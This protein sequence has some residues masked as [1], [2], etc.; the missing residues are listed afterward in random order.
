MSEIGNIQVKADS[1][2]SVPFKILSNDNHYFVGDMLKGI[3]VYEKKAVGVSYLCFIECK[4][5]K[6]FELADNRLFCNNMVD[7]VV[8][9]VRDPVEIN[10]LHRQKNHFNRFTNYKEYWNIPYVEGKGLIVG[11]EIHELT[12]MITEK[13]SE[14][15]FSNYDELYGNLTTKV[16]PDNWFSNHPEYDKPYIGMINLGTN[17]IYNYGSYNS[18]TIS[19]YRWGVFSVREEDL[20]TSPRGN[21]APPY[22]YS[23]AFPV[24]MFFEDNLIYILGTGYS[25]SGYCDCITYNE[26]Y[27]LTYHLYFPNFKP[28]DI[29]YLPTMQAFFVV[30]GQSVWGAFK[31][32]ETVYMERYVDYEIPTDATSIFI[33]GNNLITLGNQLSVYS[34]FENELKLV[35][36]YPDISGTCYLKKGDVLAV[37]N[38]QG[39]FFYDITDLKNIRLIP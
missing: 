3:H 30:S 6:D 38:T 27:P 7:M 28:V 32:S 34:P 4:N 2:F 22:Y 29:T 18:W 17:E 16:I 9:D 8:I 35:K 39:M 5:I 25:N 15:D 26:S 23:N 21:Y 31:S 37:A 33:A 11:T 1:P 10:I 14:L 20:W 24:R 13:Q 12:G 36:N 19:S